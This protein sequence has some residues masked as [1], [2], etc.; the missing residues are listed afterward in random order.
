MLKIISFLGADG[1]GKSTLLKLLETDLKYR[2]SKVKI[3]VIHFK[4]TI[5][6]NNIDG[7]VLPYNKKPHN[8]FISVAKLIVWYCEYILFFIIMF[9]ENIFSDLV[10]IFD[11]H[12]IDIKVDPLRYRMNNFVSRLPF[13]TFIFPKPDIIFY[14]DGEPKT[15]NKRK[16]EVS[17]DETVQQIERYRNILKNIKNVVVINNE[18]SIEDSYR[19]ICKTVFK[20]LKIENTTSA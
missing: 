13:Y 5:R 3:K 10:V 11:R 17:L 16:I 15:I 2:T 1:A 9:L 18:Q 8:L 7:I 19:I 6:K 4:P 14:I 12:L 20:V